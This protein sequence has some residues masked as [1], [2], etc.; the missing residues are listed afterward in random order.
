MTGGNQGTQSRIIQPGALDSDRV[1]ASNSAQ[2]Q[3]SRLFQEAFVGSLQ[4]FFER[5]LR[6]PA[7]TL[8]QAD[9]GQFS[10][11]SIGLGSVR[12]NASVV[13]HNPT[14]HLGQL[15]DLQVDTSADVD[16]VGRIFELKEMQQGRSQ[17]INV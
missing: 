2:G 1:R 5:D 17:V 11:G 15:H 9:I 3:V 14:D 7:C 16:P 8:E 6:L 10:W 12:R 13:S 4:A